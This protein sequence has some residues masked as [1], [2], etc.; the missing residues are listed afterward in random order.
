MKDEEMK[1]K[2]EHPYAPDV[3][4]R[5]AVSRNFTAQN[6][7]AVYRELIYPVLCTEGL[8]LECYYAAEDTSTMDFWINRMNII[9]EVSDIHILIDIDRTENMDFEFERSQ[10]LTRTIA[11]R[12]PA[13][14][15]NFHWEPMTKGVFLPISILVKEGKGRDKFSSRKRMG[16]IYLPSNENPEDFQKRLREQIGLAK[17][18]RIKFLKLEKMVYR[19]VASFFGAPVDGVKNTLVEVTK[20][21]EAI[22]DRKMV[23]DLQPIIELYAHPFE[24]PT[25]ESVQIKVNEHHDWLIKLRQGKLTPPDSLRDTYSM[26][27]EHYRQS[28]AE[29][30]GKEFAESRFGKVIT[31]FASILATIKVRRV[32][33]KRRQK[34]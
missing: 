20:I 25:T 30:F 23:P 19:K 2:V 24:L 10:E 15:S 4:W 9:L 8:V 27:R 26:V 18:N 13:L 21:A 17:L 5:I 11:G 7:D 14:S 12:T 3:Q 33:R 29:I 28:F 6:V 32:V 1:M 16:I 34:V 22:A 31:I